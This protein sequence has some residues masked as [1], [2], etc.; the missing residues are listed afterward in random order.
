[1]FERF[2]FDMLEFDMF[3]LLGLMFEFI[4]GDAAGATVAAGVERFMFEFMFE[5]LALLAGAPQAMPRALTPRTAE[6][7][8]TFFILFANSCLSQRM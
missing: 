5:L 2:M 3:E 8:I 6:S 1:M 4:A 7:T